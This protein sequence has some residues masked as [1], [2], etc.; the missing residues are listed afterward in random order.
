VFVMEKKDKDYEDESL[1]ERCKKCGKSN[2][3]LINT[4]K[5]LLCRKCLSRER[6]EFEEETEDAWWDE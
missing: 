1:V 4:E 5:G 6:N 3:S 2:D